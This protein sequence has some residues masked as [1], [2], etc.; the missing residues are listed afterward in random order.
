MATA[1]S[2]DKTVNMK[3][4]AIQAQQLKD[5][6]GNAVNVADLVTIGGT[7][8]TVVATTGTITTLNGVPTAEIQ[9]VDPSQKVV[10]FDDFLAGANLDPRNSSTAGAGT[11]NAAL[12]KVSNSLN[13]EATLTTSSASG[14][15]AQNASNLTLDELNFK[16]SGG[17]LAFETRL[18]IDVITN[19]VIMVGFTDTIST[20]VELPICKTN[21]A[22]T[23][24][25]D[26]TDACGIFF[27]TQGTTDTFWLGGVKADVDVTPLDSTVAP[28]AATYITLR[29]EVSAAG[30]VTGYVNGTSIGTIAN[31]VTTS[32]AL[33]PTIVVSNRTASVKVLT[34]DY[35]WVA[36]TRA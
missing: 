16:A 17:G 4:L 21:A 35:W 3:S 26:A 6:N 8:G 22:D 29:V 19:A 32:V 10:F 24:A 30:A 7:T 31:A 2:K 12:T 23:Q 5:N 1:L 27:D 15:N 9:T 25:S 18:K 36:A 28:V 14:T 11:G 13:G 20:T 34:I 33:T